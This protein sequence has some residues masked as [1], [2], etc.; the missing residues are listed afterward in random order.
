[1]DLFAAF[2]I[3]LVFL[4]LH[5]K[6]QGRAGFPEYPAQNGHGGQKVNNNGEPT[7]WLIQLSE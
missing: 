2:L 5:Y 1:M 4:N 7:D 3:F 6:I